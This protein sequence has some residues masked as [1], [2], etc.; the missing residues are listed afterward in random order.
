MRLPRV[1]FRVRRMMV[2]VAL[3]AVALAAWVLVPPWW[4]Y[5]QSIKNLTG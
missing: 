3:A 5:H 4:Q 1:R 2:V